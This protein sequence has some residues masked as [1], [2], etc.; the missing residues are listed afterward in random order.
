MITIVPLA[1]FGNRMLALAS[2]YH[3]AKRYH[4]ELTVLWNHDSS[5]AVD[6]Q[7]VLETPNNMT[8][9]TVT[10][11]SFRRSPLKVLFT[12]YIYKKYKK[13]SFYYVCGKDWC[14]LPETIRYDEIEETIR[15]HENVYIRSWTCFARE[16]EVDF[17]FIQP[18][19][20][21]LKRG[22]ALFEQIG[23]D[24]YGVHIRRTDHV[25][26]IANSP[27]VLFENRMLEIL[28]LNPKAKFYVA[29]DDEQTKLELKDKF[30]D[31]IIIF[32][33]AKLSRKS[34]DGAIDAV[35]EIFA[36]SKCRKI[37]GSYESTFSK[38]ASLIGNNELEII[39]KED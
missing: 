27:T 12:R 6:M 23:K 8:V 1:G 15:T 20:K 36:L 30:A 3:F 25:N 2:A 32:E 24:T 33:G 9:I 19:E 26:A 37:L 14:A 4:G 21:V 31:R 16:A 35:V 34:T 7:D 18:S 13:K 39:K 11:N 38:V 10:E 22:K 29:S 28:S 5:F 17:Q